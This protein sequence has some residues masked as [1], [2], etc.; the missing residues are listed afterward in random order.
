MHARWY[1]PTAATF[2][3]R[4]DITLYPTPVAAAANRYTYA[5]ADPINLTDPTGHNPCSGGGHYQDTAWEE[6]YSATS[7]CDKDSIGLP[8]GKGYVPGPAAETPAADQPAAGAA[9]DR[10]A[11]AAAAEQRHDPSPSPNHPRTRGTQATHRSPSTG[12][13]ASHRTATG[14]P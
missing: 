5:N 6:G 7:D 11:A 13:A 10:Q 4:D 9:A 2:R 14:R 8:P 1:N 3:S 12:Q